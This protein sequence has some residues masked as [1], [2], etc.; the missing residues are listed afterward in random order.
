[1][2]GSRAVR[3]GATGVPMS[4]ERAVTAARPASLAGRLLAFSIAVMME[5]T[6]FSFCKRITHLSRERRV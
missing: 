3:K 5:S 2:T 4:L 1:M 6:I